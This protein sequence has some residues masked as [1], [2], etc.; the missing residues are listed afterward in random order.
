MQLSYNDLTGDH[1]IYFILCLMGV[2]LLFLES[3]KHQDV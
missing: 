3:Y 2:R 1:F